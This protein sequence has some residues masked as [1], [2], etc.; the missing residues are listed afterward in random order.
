M[1]LC[2]VKASKKRGVVSRARLLRCCGS[3]GA[4]ELL[5]PPSGSGPGDRVTFLRYPGNHGY[6][7]KSC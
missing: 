7:F 6:G 4:A 2:N 3:E 1:V 5:A